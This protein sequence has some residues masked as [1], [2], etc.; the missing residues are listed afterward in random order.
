MAVTRFDVRVNVRSPG[1]TRGISIEDKQAIFDKPLVSRT[2]DKD[3][4]SINRST[5]EGQEEAEEELPSLEE[6]SEAY[7]ELIDMAEALLA[8][9]QERVG[10][11][12]YEFNPQEKPVLS[13]A[14]ASVFQ[15]V[16]D[17]ITYPMYIAALRLDKDIA[18]ALGESENGLARQTLSST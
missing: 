9:L 13:E 2:K 7:T 12:P 14:V 8:K 10:P 6:I 4:G 5:L 1:E 15:G 11:L 18:V 17:K 3:A 16:H